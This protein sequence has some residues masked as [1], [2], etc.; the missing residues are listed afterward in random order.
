MRNELIEALRDKLVQ[1][2]KIRRNLEYTHNKVA[3]WWRV[4]VGFDQWNEDQLELLAAFKARFSELQD[5]LASA[6]KLIAG[7]EGERAEAFTYVLNFMVQIYVLESVDEWR[8]V[9]DLRNAATH[10]YSDTEEA[11]AIHFH[12]L[13]QNTHYLYETQDKLAHFADKAYSIKQ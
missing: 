3:N 1:L 6:M 9:R 8:N 7:I 11:K 10:D 5:H 12:R 13:I 2:K 4:D